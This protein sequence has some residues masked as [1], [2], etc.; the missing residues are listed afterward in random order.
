MVPGAE[1]RALPRVPHG[2]GVVAEQVVR[3][4][5]PPAPPGPHDEVPVGEA[6]T[7]RGRHAERAAERIAVVE[8]GVRG[9][10]EAGLDAQRRIGALVRWPAPATEDDGAVRPLGG[11]RSVAGERRQD[12]GHALRLAR[13]FPK[14]PADRVHRE[15][16][17]NNRMTAGTP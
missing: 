3:A 15:R 11:V 5:P 16:I 8:P 13:R 12:G 17:V 9:H 4:V 10:R 7:G 14:E 1:E 6:A 2:E